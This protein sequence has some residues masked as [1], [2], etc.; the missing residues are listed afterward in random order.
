[1]HTAI[2]RIGYTRHASNIAVITHGVAA[3]I[4]SSIGSINPSLNGAGEINRCEFA[5]TE[6]KEMGRSLGS[7]ITVAPQDL[8][9]VVDLIRLASERAGD[10][11]CREATLPEKK[12]VGT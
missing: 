11:N 6:Q 12:T 4:E 3:R 8:A 10:I 1:M 5:V 9:A 7:V 2:Q